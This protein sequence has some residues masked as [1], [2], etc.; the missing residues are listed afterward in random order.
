VARSKIVSGTSPTIPVTRATVTI[1]NPT[2]IVTAAITTTAMLLKTE[3][4][5]KKK[6]INSRNDFEYMDCQVEFRHDQDSLHHQAKIRKEALPSSTPGFGN[7]AFETRMARSE[8]VS[9]TSVAA[10][11]SF[12]EVP[13]APTSLELRH[14]IPVPKKY[15]LKKTK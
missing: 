15:K 2:T 12:T 6:K 1:R 4:K 9:T 11:I 13:V 5:K 7:I 14:N 8:V 10:P 3:E